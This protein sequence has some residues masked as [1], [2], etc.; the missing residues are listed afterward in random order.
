MADGFIPGTGALPYLLWLAAVILVAG[1]LEI[2]PVYLIL[3]RTTR[4][5]TRLLIPAM[6]L[7]LGFIP[8]MQFDLDLLVLAS[9]LVIGPVAA[10]IPNCVAPERTPPESRFF[11]V[12]ICYVMVTLFGMAIILAWF[13]PVRSMVREFYQHSLL[14]NAIIYAGVIALDTAFSLFIYFFIVTYRE[15]QGGR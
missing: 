10:L 11:R 1:A 5:G 6:V 2:L 8:M 13:W 7:V 12:V 15:G 4:R 9:F 3:K 14:S